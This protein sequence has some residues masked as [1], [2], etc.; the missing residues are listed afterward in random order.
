[1]MSELPNKISKYKVIDTIG[2]GAMG[3]VYKGLDELIDRQVAIKTMIAQTGEGDTSQQRFIS[4]AKALA[5]CHHPNIVTVLEF[6]YQEEM[7]YMVMEYLPGDD[8]KK[9]MQKNPLFS[10]KKAFSIFAQLLKALHVVHGMGITHRDIKPENVLMASQSLVKLSDFGVAKSSVDP[11]KTQIGMTVGTPRYMAP[12][13]MFGTHEVGSFTDI[14]A[15]FVI[16]YELLSQVKYSSNVSTSQLSHLDQLPQH[17]QFAEDTLIPVELLGFMT[18][19]LSVSPQ[20]RFQNIKSVVDAFKH[21][22]TQMSQDN[23]A[24]EESTGSGYLSS[25]SI[26][27]QGRTEMALSKD[28]IQMVRE[29]LTEYVGPMADLIV[30]KAN[31][32]SHSREQF[33]Q[34]IAEKVDNATIR[35]QFTDLWLK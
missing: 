26:I 10:L 20:E 34:V 16:F 7:A 9:W 30:N 1:M 4:E 18:K 2:Q 33:I 21:C 25:G 17:N 22:V 6:G 29:F 15:L 27:S 31:K 28:E 23:R 32:E 24:G 11:S 12:E 13:Q 14:Y 8:L 35:D 3:V 5:K 19:G